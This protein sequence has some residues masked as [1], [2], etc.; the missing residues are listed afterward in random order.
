MIFFFF[1]FVFCLKADCCSEINGIGLSLYVKSI[2]LFFCPMAS[3]LGCIMCE[4]SPKS[5]YFLILSFS[6]C[7]SVNTEHLPC[8][9]LLSH[10]RV[11]VSHST[12]NAGPTNKHPRTGRLCLSSLSWKVNPATPTTTSWSL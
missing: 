11:P 1:Q 10:N 3:L 2:V 7:E 8:L 4:P 12:S 9:I 6:R 5:L